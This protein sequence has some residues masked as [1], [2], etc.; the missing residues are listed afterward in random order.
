VIR[1]VQLDRV[2]G[3]LFLSTMPGRERPLDDDIQAIHESGVD[4]AV[5]LTYLNEIKVKSPDYAE[6]IENDALPFK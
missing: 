1:K 3:H 4:Y 5:C 2:S 6:V